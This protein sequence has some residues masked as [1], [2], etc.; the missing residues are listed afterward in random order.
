MGLDEP[1]QSDASPATPDAGR[2]VAAKHRIGYVIGVDVA[3]GQV[4]EAGGGEHQ[5]PA[6]SLHT[7]MVCIGQTARK[8]QTIV[9]VSSR[10]V[11][12]YFLCRT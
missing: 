9:E 12:H 8:D 1:P 6:K 5:R 4:F 7:K 2:S 3:L 11:R 10:R